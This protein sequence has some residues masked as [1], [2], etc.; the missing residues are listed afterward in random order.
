MAFRAAI[1]VAALTFVGATA[2]HADVPGVIAQSARTA[3]D[4]VRDSVLTVARTTR[5]FVFGGTPAAEDT[6]YD[7]VDAMRARARRNADR[8]R[9]EAGVAARPAYRDYPDDRD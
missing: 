3:A 5:A 6:W 4:S 1:M 9:A 8:V 2:A 7:N